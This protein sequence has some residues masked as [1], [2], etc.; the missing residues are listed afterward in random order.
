MDTLEI[1]GK[2]L[3]ILLKTLGLIKTVEPV[4]P[5]T[6]QS[7][8]ISKFLF[9]S[10]KLTER[11]E[12]KYPQ[13]K[14]FIVSGQAAFYKT[15]ARELVKAINNH[16]DL[17]SATSSPEKQWTKV[18]LVCGPMV[19]KTGEW[20]KKNPRLISGKD[21]GN[22]RFVAMNKAA[23]ADHFK[24][25]ANYLVTFFSE[26]FPK[27]S[28]RAYTSNAYDKKEID[29]N[30]TDVDI[31]LCSAGPLA[32]NSNFH[33]EQSYISG[34][35]SKLTNTA[36]PK[37][38][39][40]DFCLTPINSRGKTVKLKQGLLEAMDPYPQFKSLTDIKSTT[41]IF[42]VNTGRIS[43]N[44]KKPSLTGKELVSKTILQS[45]IV[46]TCILNSELGDNL[47]KSIGN[48]VIKAVSSKR[49]HAT[50]NRA[51]FAYRLQ[52]NTE[53]A[54]LEKNETDN[55][56][57]TIVAYDPR[58]RLDDLDCSTDSEPSIHS[59]EIPQIIFSELVVEDQKYDWEQDTGE[60]KYTI[61]TNNFSFYVDKG[62]RRPGQWG[63]VTAQLTKYYIDAF[64]RKNKKVP[65]KVWDMGCGCG[66]IGIL[67][68][69]TSNHKINNL[70]FT[71]ISS[72]AVNCA[73]RNLRQHPSIAAQIK[74]GDLFDVSEMEHEKF[75]VIAFNP[76]F[77]PMYHIEKA[78]SADSGGDSGKDVA[79]RY[80]KSVF[81][82]LEA[83][84]WSILAMPDY[85]DDGQIK[86]LLEQKFGHENVTMKERIILY[87]EHPAAPIPTAYEIRYRAEI[88]SNLKYRFETCVFGKERFI[89]FKMRH[90]IANRVK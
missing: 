3:D 76:P 47:D 23:E 19:H 35:Y 59:D 31:L 57:H 43:R 39:I 71:D 17:P 73:E 26:I 52:D 68:G 67:A 18:G 7:F 15:I 9:S 1:L 32:A 69:T 51:C 83:G 55:T 70:L 42:P 25:S 81:E 84:G 79:E 2:I 64:I 75:G 11:L 85:I 90:Y 89:S 48:Y 78:L 88:E 36:F 80:C 56:L 13:T 16:S 30:R 74:T 54:D 24:Y 87:P 82:H 58:N 77:L 20:I 33:A 40:G 62:V 6:R 4:L 46:D 28:L 27:S 21:F 34:W 44:E 63:L 38:C 22:L 14:F 61:G 37:E 12:K 53:I 5:K 49:Y 65:L 41:I 86:I 50:H 60:F 10:S 45:N 66:F 72:R 8:S 29:S